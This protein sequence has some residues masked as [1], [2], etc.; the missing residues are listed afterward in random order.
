MVKKLTARSVLSL[1]PRDDRYEVGDPQCSGLRVVV[2]PS[3]NKSW[4]VRTRVNDQDGEEKTVKWT[5]GPVITLIGEDGREYADLADAREKARKILRDS[6]AEYDRRKQPAAPKP[7]VLTFED[8]AFGKRGYLEGHAKKKKKKTW[9][10]DELTIRRELKHWFDRPLSAITRDDIEDELDRK[11]KDEEYKTAA[12]RL[13]SLI[14]V[15]FNYAVRRRLLEFS[16]AYG[17][18][19][20]AEEKSRK[21]V[22]PPQQMGA[23]MRV[24]KAMEYPFGPFIRI[25]AHTLQRR[26]EVASMR[27][28]DLDLDSDEPTWTIPAEM[29]VPSAMAPTA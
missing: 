24:A 6:Q 16:P 3:I 20:P 15:M 13:Y 11:A 8:F 21:D 12:N 1:K 29:S 18:D 19:R 25:L 10:D 26:G 22:L 2:Q 28:A 27:W 17:V 9:R 5:L 4:A 14:S 23:Y 7:K